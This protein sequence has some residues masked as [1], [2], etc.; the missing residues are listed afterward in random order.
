MNYDKLGIE[1]WNY[2]DWTSKYVIHSYTDFPEECKTRESVVSVW[3]SGVCNISINIIIKQS[4][5]NETSIRIQRNINNITVEHLQIND[6][7]RRVTEICFSSYKETQEIERWLSLFSE[8][9]PFLIFP[10]MSQW[11]DFSWAGNT[12]MFNM[13][14]FFSL[15]Q[16]KDDFLLSKKKF[17][18]F[19]QMK[20]ILKVNSK[21][22]NVSDISDLMWGS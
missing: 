12:N 9:C 16:V 2:T 5:M 6:S 4:T 19:E 8:R 15:S 14:L 13:L 1:L 7:L 22:C 18:G 10:F 21:T 11:S 20:R 17:E 3:A